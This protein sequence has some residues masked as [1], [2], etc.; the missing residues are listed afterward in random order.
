LDVEL[1]ALRPETTDESEV[2]HLFSVLRPN[3]NGIRV[4]HDWGMYMERDPTLVRDVDAAWGD[5][6][7]VRIPMTRIDNPEQVRLSDITIYG[8]PPEGATTGILPHGAR[9]THNRSDT[10]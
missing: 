10:F 1:V 3:A 7:E 8:A 4:E 2:N 9:A 6:I 5:V